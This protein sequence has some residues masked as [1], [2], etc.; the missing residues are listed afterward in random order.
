MQTNQELRHESARAIAGVSTGTYNENIMQMCAAE[1]FGV[2][3][4]NE[5]LL[6]FISN[7]LGFSFTNINDAMNAY[8]Q[9]VGVGMWDQVTSFGSEV[10]VFRITDASDRRITDNTEFRI[11]G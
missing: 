3:T 7:R 10:I 9:S 5:R 4:Y 1:G 8:A 6:G 11:T 2:G